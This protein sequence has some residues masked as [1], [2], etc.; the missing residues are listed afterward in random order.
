MILQI[1]G[2]TSGTSPYDVF[3]CNEA[4]TS[5]FFISG[6]TYIPP[7]V[8]ILTDDYFPGETT[9]FVKLIDLNGCVVEE[10][11]VCGTKSYQDG[12]GFIFMDGDYYT[13]Q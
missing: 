10:N 8:Y 5:C 4:N 13:F 2:T 11:I 12:I 3:L 9:L 7:D 6:L 1:T